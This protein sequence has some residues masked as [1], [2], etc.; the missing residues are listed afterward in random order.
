MTGNDYIEYQKSICEVP[1]WLKKYLYLDI[2]ERL[3]DISLLCGMEYAS[4]S[5][6]DFKLYVSRFDHSLSTALITWKLTH[7]KTQ[8]LGALFHD[9]SSPVFS[10]VIDYMNH[11]FIN[12]ESTEGY[13]EKI[14]TGSKET[15]RCFEEDNVNVDDVI[16]F[17]KFPV[18]DLKRPS[19][20]ADRLENVISSNMAWS[21]D[22]SKDDAIYI[23]NHISLEVNENGLSEISFTDRRAAD[24]Y[25]N[26]NNI[27][28]ELVHTKEDIYMMEFLGGFIKKCINYGFFHESDL[29]YLT[30][31]EIIDIIDN[32]VDIDI[33]LE[34]MWLYFKTVN[35]IPDNYNP[36][37]IKDRSINPLV[38][39]KRL[40]K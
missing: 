17:K 29:Y 12:Q 24:L 31:H 26:A 33:N 34:D 20:C 32:N 39:G 35:K 25:L 37:I 8:T 15:L 3:K 2:I 6:Y 18:V 40:V 16:N 11:D 4:K 21:G 30:E 9:I 7:D 19:I 22:L 1:E 36:P 5:I 23:V 27:I 14:I 38:N 28:N 13:T 10:H